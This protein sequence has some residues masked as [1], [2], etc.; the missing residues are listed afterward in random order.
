M[1][2]RGAAAAGRP[3]H[4]G[5][6][7]AGGAPGFS[8]PAQAA[9]GNRVHQHHRRGYH[10]AAG[11]QPLVWGGTRRGPA[12]VRP[13]P[14]QPGGCGHQRA[15]ARHHRR[16]RAADRGVARAVHPHPVRP[17]PARHRAGSG[18]RDGDRHPGRCRRGRHLRDGCGA[19]WGVG[20][21]AV[22]RLLRHAHRRGRLHPEGLPR[23]GNRRLGQPGWCGRRRR[24]DRWVRSAVSEPTFA[25]PCAR[26]PARRGGG[27]LPNPGRRRA[28]RRRA[29][30]P[31]AAAHKACSAE[32]TGH[33]P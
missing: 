18:S 17:P 13:R 27:L 6:R 28:G 16:G 29:A 20:A 32:A 22:Q 15:V 23:R 1:A 2:R 19:G 7:W 9:A 4:G 33:R 12:F 5:D 3:G 14:R 8:A 30:D 25:D 21:A 11:R 26:P 31:D 10:P 24:A